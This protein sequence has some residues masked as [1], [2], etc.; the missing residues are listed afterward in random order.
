M[1]DSVQI[2][3]NIPLEE[4]IMGA[5]IYNKYV[6]SLKMERQATAEALALDAAA[7]QKSR[8]AAYDDVADIADFQDDDELPD[9]EDD[10]LDDPDSDLDDILD[11]DD[12]D[13]DDPEPWEEP[14]LDEPFDDLEDE[15]DDE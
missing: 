6:N 2:P 1:T 13:L 15:D 7:A 9:P 10:F 4:Q 14:D 12:L 3:G 11:E 5:F 8:R